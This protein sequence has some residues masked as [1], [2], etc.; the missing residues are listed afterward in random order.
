MSQILRPD[1]IGNVLNKLNE[2]I[3]A[4]QVISMA[5]LLIKK[6]R[7]NNGEKRIAARVN[8][9]ELLRSKWSLIKHKSLV[10]HV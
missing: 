3:G 6:V 1:T 10:G 4:L 7:A 5:M 9:V 8:C 2:G